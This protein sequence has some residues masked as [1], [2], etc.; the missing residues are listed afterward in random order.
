MPPPQ[1]DTKDKDGRPLTDRYNA[2][3]VAGHRNDMPADIEGVWRNFVLCVDGE[4]PDSNV[5]GN[6]WGPKSE[7]FESTCNRCHTTASQATYP[8]NIAG[9]NFHQFQ[10]MT[11]LKPSHSVQEDCYDEIK[12]FLMG[13][14]PSPYEQY[15]N[16]ACQ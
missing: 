12:A 13:G 9:M 1:G 3:C 5:C 16:P 4:G 15:M 2:A 8:E 7:C 11:T 14:D 6:P 10:W